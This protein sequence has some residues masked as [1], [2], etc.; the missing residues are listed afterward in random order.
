VENIEALSVS[1][2]DAHA[3][4]PRWQQPSKFRQ[5]SFGRAKLPCASAPTECDADV[6]GHTV[7]KVD[8]LI[9]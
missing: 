7:G 6:S 9:F 1:E 3:L 2:A 5:Q 8:D 4:A